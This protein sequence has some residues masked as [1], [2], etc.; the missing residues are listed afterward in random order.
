MIES[1]PTSISHMAK[2]MEAVLRAR[3]IATAMLDSEMLLGYY[4]NRDR[5]DL[6]RNGD[7]SLS[8]DELA[9]VNE[10]LARRMKGEPIAYI[11]GKKEFWSLEFEVNPSV[12]I[13]RPETEFLVETVLKLAGQTSMPAQ[14]I[15]EIGTGSGAVVT[16][17]AAELVR[18]RFFAMDISLEA[19]KLAGKN[20][21]R[22]GVASRISF[23]CGN[24]CEPLKGPFDFVVSNPPYIS[25]HEYKNLSSEVTDFEP[26]E[27][28]LAGRDGTEFHRAI[29]DGVAPCL[30]AGGWLV[31]EIGYGQRGSVERM[32]RQNGKYD[33]SSSR[34]DYAGIDRVIM[35][36]RK[37]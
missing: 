19:L 22:L 31:M 25:E 33:Y 17:L 21:A 24:L 13:P 5:V 4:L 15:L 26:K 8:N 11:V 3:G 18:G 20:A 32:L 6:Y 2:K 16:A 14:H 12:L 36:Q 1:S 35:A 23:F 9:A 27:A 10:G 30:K 29:I 7:S 37:E 34:C 28:L